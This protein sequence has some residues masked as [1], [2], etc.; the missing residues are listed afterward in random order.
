MP[1]SQGRRLT[2]SGVIVFLG[3]LL[4]ASA[5]GKRSLADAM[6]QVGEQ[7]E[8]VAGAVV[9]DASGARRGIAK[10]VET[11]QELGGDEALNREMQRSLTQMREALLT[12]S[13]L[14][15]A[16]RPEEA[17]AQRLAIERLCEQCHQEYRLAT[18]MRRMM[19][20]YNQVADAFVR[21]RYEQVVEGMHVLQGQ[22]EWFRRWVPAT[23]TVFHEEAQRLLDL[24]RQVAQAALVGDR[25]STQE[26]LQQLID[27]CPACHQAYADNARWRALV[28]RY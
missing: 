18:V 13:A 11:L 5:G 8:S 12:L 6:R 21:G 15:R 1:M 28:K 24:A 3:G 27:S 4:A 16:Q 7:W 22:T 19:E 10:L 26:R 23:E 25:A 17:W 9:F 2:L 20:V 14:L